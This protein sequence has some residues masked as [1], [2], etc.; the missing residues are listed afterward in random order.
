MKIWVLNLVGVS[1]MGILLEILLPTGKTNK[2]IK[3]VLALVTVYVVVSPIIKIFNNEISIKN[4]FTTDIVIDE[5]FIF[6]TSQSYF[7]KEEKRLEDIL[8]KNGIENVKVDIV[9]SINGQN[10]IE[11]VKICTKNMTLK[12]DYS[13]IDIIGKIEEIV[14]SRLKIDSGRIYYE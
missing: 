9:P 1:L 5:E 2:Y 4:F 3:G 7:E 10:K 12:K 14:K 11:F 8:E 13:N 6:K